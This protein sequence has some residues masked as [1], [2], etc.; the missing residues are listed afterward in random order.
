MVLGASFFW[1]EAPA[2]A[3]T[4]E[5]AVIQV[6]G[7]GASS[8]V[9]R[10][11][12]WAPTGRYGHV[13]CAGADFDWRPAQDFVSPASGSNV[14][15]VTVSNRAP[16]FFRVFVSPVPGLKFVQV[17][18]GAFSMGDPYAEGSSDELPVHTVN[19]GRFYISQ[20]EVTVEQYTRYLN[21][22]R[23]AGLIERVTL[24]SDD[25]VPGGTPFY[26]DIY[27]VRASSGGYRPLYCVYNTSDP[28]GDTNFR[29]YWTGSQFAYHSTW[30][31]HPAPLM[32]WYGARAFCQFYGGDLATEAEWEKAARAGRA[33]DH[34]PWASVGGDFTAHI[35]ANRANYWNSGD[36]WEYDYPQTTPVMYYAAWSN[37]YGLFDMAGNAYEWVRDW[38]DADYYQDCFNQGTVT[39]PAG[40]GSGTYKTLR[41][42]SYYD[43]P[44][45][46]E[47]ELYQ[48]KLR[49]ANRLET[50]PPEDIHFNIGI[51][52]VLH[53]DP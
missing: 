23:A 10:L 40:P 5:F 25:D 8:Q 33:G 43:P 37:A 45:D 38:Y 53:P 6:T 35:S 31:T 9:V 52:M 41:G 34:Y 39:N 50:E 7:L 14:V 12:F 2:A 3:R 26:G 15:T 19:V 24:E 16:A 20:T 11:E 29:I 32:S 36:A 4:G 30:R 48:W 1:P 18:P 49:T 17:P 42:G 28:P 51:R 46:A 47:E 27:A 44:D 21:D 22:A 13:E